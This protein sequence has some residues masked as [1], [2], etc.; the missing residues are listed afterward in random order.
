MFLSG[1]LS[2]ITYELKDSFVNVPN[3]ESEFPETVLCE[4]DK[5]QLYFKF[6]N[7]TKDKKK[8]TYR[9]H[10]IISQECYAATLLQYRDDADLLLNLTQSPR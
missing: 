5:C 10:N 1:S 8:V 4:M 7:V 2:S 9:R 6:D 3:I